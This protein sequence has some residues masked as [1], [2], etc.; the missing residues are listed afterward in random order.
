MSLNVV[1]NATYVPIVA[2]NHVHSC[3]T[4]YYAQKFDRL[5]SKGAIILK[6]IYIILLYHYKTYHVHCFYLIATISYLPLTSP[7]PANLS[8]PPAQ[9]VQPNIII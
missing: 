7:S 9:L 2:Y 4:N 8:L 3:T 1:V 5:D 6:H